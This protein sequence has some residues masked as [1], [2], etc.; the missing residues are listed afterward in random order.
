[1]EYSY[2]A[3]IL[4]QDRPYRSQSVQ[5]GLATSSVTTRLL[6]LEYLRKGCK[7][8]TFA[9]LLTLAGRAAIALAH[10]ATSTSMPADENFLKLLD[11]IIVIGAE[12]IDRVGEPLRQHGEGWCGLF[13][14]SIEDVKI[15]LLARNFCSKHSS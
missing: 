14:L 12:H 3:S 9:F 7:A 5:R 8:K 6:M 11:S 2:R 15:P 13:K 4:P 10:R 1:M